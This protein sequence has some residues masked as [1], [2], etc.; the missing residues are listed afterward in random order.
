[1]QEFPKHVQAWLLPEQ[2]PDPKL[3]PTGSAANQ[4]FRWSSSNF[5]PEVLTDNTRLPLEALPGEQEH[6]ALHSLRY[7]A[8]PGRYIYVRI[9]AGMRS[10]GG[11]VL[12]E[13]V[14]RIIQ[15]PQFPREV[16]IL[17]EGSLLALS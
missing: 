15:V 9:A 1:E 11:Y 12:G 10:F 4:P 16:S 5:R 3:R 14:E 6:N 2:H 13:T 7:Q 17:H 8:Q